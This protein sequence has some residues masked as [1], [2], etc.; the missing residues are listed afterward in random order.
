MTG[1][2]LV[3]GLGDLG[4]WVLELLARSPGVTKI[5]T[6]D[7]DREKGIR[8]TNI[9]QLGAAHM[10]F[11]PDMHFVQ[12]D[13][14]QIDATVKIIKEAQP[15]V[16]FASMTLQS[17]WMLELL[18]TKVRKELEQAG[19]GPWLPMHLTLMY[20][21]MKAVK[22]SG[23]HA[24]VVS[25]PFPDAVNPVLDKVGLAPTCGIGNFDELASIIK[26]AVS[27]KLNVPMQ[28]ISIFMI[29]HHYTN[30]ALTEYAR[31]GDAP[32]YLKI[33]VGDNNVTSKLNLDEIFSSRPPIPPGRGVH[34]L[35]ASTAARNILAIINDTRELTHAPG[36]NG[37]PGGYPVRLG[38]KGAEVFVPEELTLKDA[39]RINEEAQKYD[40]I[41]KIRA[42]GSVV[43]TDRSVEI[44][45][46]V[47]GYDC[48]ELKIDESEERAKELRLLFE[49][50]V[51]KCQNS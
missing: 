24:H 29:G 5:V 36:P 48:K 33:L 45:K 44:V 30:V 31:K 14:N 25:S 9:A 32:F 38:A 23:T 11:Y 37:L 40:G 19:F 50:L 51:K 42:D 26:K 17:W 34:P 27:E 43:F 12:V 10:G 2:V 22:A 8:K 21:L 16:I 47:L 13:L 39:I 15:N 41:K 49:S 20:K 28:N 1:A 46:R 18:P 35:T 4:G 6:A 3:F 7:I